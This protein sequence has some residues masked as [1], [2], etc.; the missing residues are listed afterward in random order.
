MTSERAAESVANSPST[1]AHS[2]H[3]TS[4]NT[5]FP[6]IDI[7]PLFT[8]DQS[9]RQ[10]CIDQ[11]KHACLT[12]GFFGAQGACSQDLISRV[13]R[14]SAAFHSLSDA[15]KRPYYSLEKVITRGWVPLH[16]EPAYE[17]GT[18][19]HVESFDLGLHLPP[20]DPDYMESPLL[21]PNVYPDLIGFQ[22]DIDTYYA[23]INRMGSALLEAF[24]EML[25]LERNTF[26]QMS[27]RRA[28]SKMRLLHYPGAD[29]QDRQ[30]EESSSPEGV[31][32]GIS[33][34]SDFEMLTIMHQNAP[35]LQ[36]LSRAGEWVDVPVIPDAFSVI[37]DDALEFL[38]NGVLRATHHRVPLTTWERYSLIVFHAADVDQVL[39]PLPEFVSPENPPRYQPITQAAHI[40]QQTYAGIDNSREMEQL[41]S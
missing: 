29:D 34:H 25:G 37:L 2:T 22:E 17:P 15:D 10:H 12:V 32:V 31:K 23:E 4:E 28:G 20:D 14:Q 11:I 6:I 35:G 26:R 40:L 41:A 3:I 38:T 5:S 7:A 24:A 27:T 18:I 30:P 9:S 13:Y 16:E 1:D 39:Q 19:S 8:E 21:E 33:S 36:L